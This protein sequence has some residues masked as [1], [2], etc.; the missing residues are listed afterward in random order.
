MTPRKP[1]PGPKSNPASKSKAPRP[2]R[3]PLLELVEIPARPPAMTPLRPGDIAPEGRWKRSLE[4]IA[5][6]W[7]RRYVECRHGLYYSPFWTRFSFNKHIN[8]VHGEW[9]GYTADAIVRL[10]N[11]LP[12]SWIAS[13]KQEW[14]ENVLASQDPDGYIGINRP[15]VRWNAGFEIW[16]QDRMMQSLLYEYEASGDTRILSACIGMAKCL[17]RHLDTDWFRGVWSRP[18]T[19]PGPYQAG[20]AL[21]IVHPLLRLYEYTGD[22]E[23]LQMVVSMYED[24][25]QCGTTINARAFLSVGSIMTHIV[26]VCEHMSIPA[27]LYAFTG[28][29]Q[30]LEASERAFRLLNDCMQVTGI[31]SGNE[32]TYG[33]GPRKY[34]EH[35]GVVE[36]AISCNRLLEQTGNVAYADSAER[37]MLN[38]YFGSKSPDGVTLCYNHAPNQ[39]VATDWSGPYEDNWDR[40][41][42]RNH[43][44]MIHEPRCCNANTS[45]GFPNYI[46]ASV[47]KDENGFPAFT[48]YG[49]MTAE[50]EVSGAGR[51]TFKQEADYPFEDE[52]RFTIGLDEPARFPVRFRVPGWCRSAAIS[53]N[54]KPSGVETGPGRFALIERE[55]QDGDTV[56]I[57][58]DIPIT[59]HWYTE[60]W[61]AVPAV[62]VIRGPLTFTLP[63]E[64]EWVYIGKGEPGPENI[65]EEWN[66]IPK[67]GSLWNVALEIDTS[68]VEKSFR[69]VRRKEPKGAL[70]WQHAP[71]GLEV[72]A[73]ALPDWRTD[74]V[75]G[76]P[77]T[78]ALPQPP[79]KPATESITVT[80]V[81][82]GF[83]HLHMTCLPVVGIESKEAAL[84]NEGKARE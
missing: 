54:G 52:V 27:K 29:S 74:T 50:T 1:R 35:C 5:D 64:E 56:K 7:L 75:N 46:A 8:D 68:D 16:A 77:Q 55:W 78:P 19:L 33:K 25:N 17:A 80:L 22:E 62:S 28:E 83:T 49:P 51:V 40:G 20:H 12:D 43:Y 47:M 48:L 3:H 31:I 65:D 60:S 76:K 21:N 26:T 6:G 9:A 36:W 53:I 34:T 61:V 72:K 81:P 4:V 82:F 71:I 73:R 39:V 38:A 15:E 41:M 63:V 23:I 14:L 79:L 45:R 58:F 70:P 69:L 84:G 44:S 67:D 42:F 57:A 18:R 66:V 10:A 30:Y 37:A 59:L 24:F 32:F 2:E 11:L 13:R